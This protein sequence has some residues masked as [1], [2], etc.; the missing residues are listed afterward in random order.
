MN[1]DIDNLIVEDELDDQ[2][3][4]LLLAELLNSTAQ[5]EQLVADLVGRSAGRCTAK[6]RIMLRSMSESEF[7]DG[8]GMCA[9][10]FCSASSCC[11]LCFSAMSWMQGV[12]NDN[13]ST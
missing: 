13:K 6:R 5:V 10:S 12:R 3:G 8:G 2:L 9:E 4:D 11:V 1:M 7:C